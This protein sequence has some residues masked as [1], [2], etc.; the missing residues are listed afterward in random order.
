M[1]E[2]ES[3]S[4]DSII[5]NIESEF[6]EFKELKDH[7]SRLV[8]TDIEISKPSYEP[9]Q[10]DFSII[11]DGNQCMAGYISLESNKELHI[12]EI[13]HCGGNNISLLLTFLKKIS[14]V[15]RALITI[16]D[17][18][19]FEFLNIESNEETSI[20]LKKLYTL[21]EGLTYYDKYLNP[22]KG[23]VYFH[24][25]IAFFEENKD[26]FTKPEFTKIQEILD[27]GNINTI[28]DFF[29]KI[30]EWLKSNSHN[31]NGVKLVN[32]E[33][34]NNLLL[35]ADIIDKTYKIFKRYKGGK[36]SKV[37]KC[38]RKSKRKCKR[39]SKKLI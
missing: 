4:R 16:E 35:Y 18:S 21:S 32:N 2:D 6:K 27:E 9:S 24:T 11:N 5:E 19:K 14:V 3:D 34:W 38:K 31:G 15:Y 28:G 23:R 25:P 17:A 13:T 30:R 10:I 8:K 36:S 7:I 22:E 33:N 37:R 26:K 29:M 39:K 1:N 12:S 20:E